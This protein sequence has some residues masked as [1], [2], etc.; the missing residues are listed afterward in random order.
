MCYYGSSGKT[1]PIWS[2][3]SGDDEPVPKIGNPQMES[4]TGG[5]GEGKRI[6][7]IWRWGELILVSRSEPL[8]EELEEDGVEEGDTNAWKR[9]L[10]A[11]RRVVFSLTAETRS[12]DG[13]RGRI[14]LVKWR[15]S[16]W[17]NAHVSWVEEAGREVNEKKVFPIDLWKIYQWGKHTCQV[18]PFYAVCV[19][20]FCY[21][22][23][24]IKWKGVSKAKQFLSIHPLF[25]TTLSLF[26][27]SQVFAGINPSCLWVRA[28]YT[29][30]KS[31]A[32]G[33]AFTDGRGC[34]A[35]WGSVL[36]KELKF[37]STVI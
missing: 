19:P 28:G 11:E 35:R 9:Q 17:R 21:L 10:T 24:V 4:D 33:R 1:C 3:I 37:A 5:G 15:E 2:H 36:C 34:H 12:V 31:P 30:D 8:D 27:A 29:L 14:W 7:V 25:V 26:M 23:L 13:V 18:L 6:L 20:Q 22:D 32:H 16:T